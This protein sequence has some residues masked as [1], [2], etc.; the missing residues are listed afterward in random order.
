MIKADLS[1]AVKMNFEEW[2]VYITPPHERQSS[3]ESDWYTKVEKLR[4]VR[5]TDVEAHVYNTGK[6]NPS[7]R[8]A[9]MLFLP[10][11]QTYFALECEV[12]S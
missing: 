6:I 4:D 2:K 11:S 9:E 1:K 3:K 7:N 12:I 10:E 5:I 8:S